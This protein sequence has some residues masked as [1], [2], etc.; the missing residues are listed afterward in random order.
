MDA[1]QLRKAFTEFFVERGH[2]PVPSAGLI[3]HHPAAPLLNN[4][5]M[6]QFIPVMIGEVPPPYPRAV[7]VQKCFRTQDI[8]I[9]GDTTRHLTFFEMMGNFSFGDYFKETAIPL[10]WELVTDVLGLDPERLW[11]TVHLD[12][13]EA[14]A[15]WRDTVGVP[16][17]RIQR[18]G[19]DNF[20]EMAKGK[21][22]P[23]GPCSEIYYDKGEEWG[24]PG[25]PLDGG[26]ERYV[27]IWNLVFMQYRR[28]PDGSLV[29]LPTRN[30][31]TGAGLERILPILQ[32]V[33]SVFDTD[34][35]RPVL[36]AAGRAIGRAY[37]S[38]PK[39][40]RSLRILADHGRAMTMLTADGV[41]PSNEDRGYIL[42]RIIRRAVRHAFGL[43]VETSVTPALVD[44]T[45]DTLGVAYPELIEKRDFI[46][47]VVGREEEAFRRTLRSGSTVIDNVL[48]KLEEAGEKVVPGAVAFQ[49]HDTFGFPLELTLEVAGEHGFDVD[50]AGF[51]DEM[52]RQKAM[53]KA[54]RKG[55][56]G[57][58]DEDRR[59][60]Y[61][62]LLDEGGP[63]QFTGY[64]ETESQARIRAVL[65][66]PGIDATDD[67]VAVDGTLEVFLDR[68]PFYSEAG[69]QVGDT[70]TI[71]TATGS[72][73]VLDTTYALPGLRRHLA[74]VVEGDVAP[75]QTATASVDGARR[76]AIRRNHTGTHL[77]HWA[78]REVL[79]DHVKQAGSLVAPDRLRFDFSHY[80]AVTPEELQRIE[81]LANQQVIEN[82]EVR[83]TE[84]SQTEAAERGAIAFFGE[85]YGDVVRVIEAGHRSV[86]LCGGTHVHA[87]G[88]IGPIK[89]LGESSIG[90]NL[91]RIEAVT[92]RASLD[93][94]RDEKATLGRAATLLRVAPP[95]VPERVEKLIEEQKALADQIRQLRKAGA[96][97]RAGELALG[98]VDGVVV[99]RVDGTSRDDLRDLALAVRDQ[100]GV[101]A[102]VLGGA[103]EGG[104]A[105]L[106]AA[107]VKDAG[108]L[109]SD[110]IAD[111]A[112]TV[113]GGGG[114]NPDIAVAGGRDP[115]RLDEAL[116]QARTAAGVA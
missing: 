93:R 72:L 88:T 107:V 104:G 18:M 44:A 67:V 43:G 71:T 62:R 14:E 96:S 57:A 7:T 85:K 61:R 17:E 91:R 95:E 116:D 101:R 23:C 103:P 11:V 2:T 102:V 109:A 33:S 82:E 46:V 50:V 25:G 83:S 75:G 80:A 98:A 86:E 30:I 34:V 20:W 105:A 63:D 24:A 22:G 87:L 108:L 79:G 3:P 41:F 9:I 27:E 37:G 78:L 16:P 6:N 69:G 100:P 5:G 59:A 48:A 77:L 1:Q 47:G 110:L 66:A 60:A 113:G 106:V 15:I 19:D 97:G 68:T 13:D 112:R 28:Q 42:R 76:D 114:K 26:P 64:D 36:D 90:A 8:E 84:M 32:G 56:E 40:D 92:G 54:A 21:P 31:D 4:A 39:V 81:D 55:P 38:D 94:I 52:S 73:E 65:A 45:V 35:V 10:A 99:A 58:T 74:R 53:G 115:G 51:D 89:I 12:D 111:A 49:L 70:G 29:D